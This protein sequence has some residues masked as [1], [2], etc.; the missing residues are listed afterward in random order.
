MDA[1]LKE[2]LGA[3][4]VGLRR[5]YETFREG[6][7]RLFDDNGWVGWQP[8]A[9]EKDVLSWFQD[10]VPRLSQLAQ[11]HSPTA[12]PTRRAIAQPDQLLEGLTANRKLDVGFVNDPKARKNSRYHWSQ[13]LVPGELKSSPKA[14]TSNIWL[15]IGRYVR[16]VLA[17]QDTRR[18]VRAFTLCGSLMRI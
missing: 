7:N 14:D 3:M 17:T 2:E 11:S 18:F 13:I 8:Q 16:E 12:T 1:V 9:K 10:I 6:S 5:F 15:A 4:Y